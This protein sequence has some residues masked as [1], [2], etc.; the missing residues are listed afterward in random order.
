MDAEQLVKLIDTGGRSA[1]RVQILIKE[2]PLSV[3]RIDPR[4]FSHTLR[5][6][7]YGQMAMVIAWPSLFPFARPGRYKNGLLVSTLSCQ[8][9]RIAH[10]CLDRYAPC[11]IS[12]EFR[13][14]LASAS[15]ERRRSAHAAPS[16]T[17]P[18]LL[19]LMQW[20]RRKFITGREHAG[21]CHA[22]MVYIQKAIP[23]VSIAS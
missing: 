15:T 12:L 5:F 3:S 7:T 1:V 6:L 8:G 23:I 9:E 22:A 18:Q 17:W 13:F 20:G 16:E 21:W 10:N 2:P 19:A 14:S 4:V 11:P